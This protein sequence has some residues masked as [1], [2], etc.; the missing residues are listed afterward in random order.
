MIEN[1]EICKIHNAQKKIYSSDF[2]LCHSPRNAPALET[3]STALPTMVC[4]T[5]LVEVVGEANPLLDVVVVK[6]P[7]MGLAGDEE[8]TAVKDVLGFTIRGGGMRNLIGGGFALCSCSLLIGLMSTPI[9][10]DGGGPMTVLVDDE[11]DE[12]VEE[13]GTTRLLT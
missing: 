3:I 5:E 12:I 10:S 9:A 1:A 6:V 13:S 8:D 4:S 2:E 11:H 7:M